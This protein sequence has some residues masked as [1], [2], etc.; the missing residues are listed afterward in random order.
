M[1]ISLNLKEKNDLGVG[2]SNALHSLRK[3]S[4]SINNESLIVI[5]LFILAPFTYFVKLSLI[6]A[7]KATFT[8]MNNRFY[9][10]SL[11][12]F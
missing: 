5:I 3:L 12:K 10:N 8:V 4:G 7:P 1:S 2:T 9:C 11:I 6:Q